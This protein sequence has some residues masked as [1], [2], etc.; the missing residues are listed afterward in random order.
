MKVFTLNGGIKGLTMPPLS[1]RLLATSSIVQI[2]VDE[3]FVIF[4]CSFSILA[5]VEAGEGDGYLGFKVV[6]V[7]DSLNQIHSGLTKV[8]STLNNTQNVTIDDFSDS[9][10]QTILGDDCAQKISSAGI[11]HSLYCTKGLFII[12]A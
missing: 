10:G 3:V 5:H 7:Q 9:I 6:A 11:F 2:V 1:S 8:R 12:K 4:F